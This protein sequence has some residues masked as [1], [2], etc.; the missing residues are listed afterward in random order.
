MKTNRYDFLQFLSQRENGEVPQENEDLVSLANDLRRA[1]ESSARNE[2][3]S[4]NGNENVTTLNAIEKFCGQITEYER[5]RI[6]QKH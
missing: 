5:H 3:Q 4:C 2:G 6:T 1:V